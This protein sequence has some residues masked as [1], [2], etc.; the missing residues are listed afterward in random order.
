[1]E[2]GVGS[3]CPSAPEV[4]SGPGGV[5]LDEQLLKIAVSNAASKTISLFNCGAAT[6]FSAFT[7]KSPISFEIAASFPPAP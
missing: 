1:V 3:D 4:T 2:I 5:D 6:S 7:N